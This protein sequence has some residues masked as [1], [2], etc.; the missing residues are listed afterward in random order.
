MQP[1]LDGALASTDGHR[2]VALTQIGV[3]AQ[4]DGHP[5]RDR[6]ALQGG[7]DGVRHLGPLRAHGGIAVAGGE[8]AQRGIIGPSI[9]VGDLLAQLGI[10]GVHDHAVEPRL[11]ARHRGQR[12]TKAP[13]AQERLL[14]GLFG[15]RLV[16]QD[17][18]GGAV[19]DR[20]PLLEPVFE[21]FFHHPPL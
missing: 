16:P 18:A 6:E 9:A 4:H 20:V 13:G 21:P 14:D 19:G 5:E 10:T 3:V 11:D 12:V 17:E 15:V 2:D 1:G 7:Q 8:G